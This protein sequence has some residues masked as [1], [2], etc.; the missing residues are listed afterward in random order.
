MPVDCIMRAKVN[1]V[2]ASISSLA[3][4]VV[5]L[6][7]ILDYDGLDLVRVP[8]IL[9]DLVRH[10][11]GRRVRCL[12]QLMREIPAAIPVPAL[13]CQEWDGCRHGGQCNDQYSQYQQRFFHGIIHPFLEGFCMFR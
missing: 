10:V 7:Q 9:V 1:A 13:P 11:E 2:T 8:A 6:D 4:M 12:S 3:R 5:K